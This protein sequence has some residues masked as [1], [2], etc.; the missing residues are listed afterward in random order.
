MLES[1]VSPCLG[2]HIQEGDTDRNDYSQSSGDPWN[3][4]EDEKV[5]EEAE[6]EEEGEEGGDGEEA[7]EEEQEEEMD[8]GEGDEEKE[9]EEEEA[10][11]E[12]HEEAEVSALALPAL[13][14]I[15]TQKKDRKKVNPG[16]GKGKGEDENVVATAEEKNHANTA[17]V[18]Q[19]KRNGKG[20]RGKSGGKRDAGQL[21]HTAKAAGVPPKPIAK[22]G[23]KGK[24]KDS[25][26]KGKGKDSAPAALVPKS[27]KNKKGNDDA[28]PD[29][30]ATTP[31][32]P[33]NNK[34]KATSQETPDKPSLPPRPASKVALC[35]TSPLFFVFMM[36]LCDVHLRG[37]LLRLVMNHS[38]ASYMM[39]LY[40]FADRSRC[41]MSLMMCLTT[42]SQKSQKSPKFQAAGGQ[43]SGSADRTTGG[44]HPKR[45]KVARTEE[46]AGIWAKTEADLMKKLDEAPQCW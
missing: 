41:M 7:E 26:P 34:R 10:E 5:E 40:M 25:A 16:K 15:K 17:A 46:I 4:L 22:P 20:G 27:G 13:E 33:P 43:P 1:S 12:E 21:G 39:C 31:S 18:A 24:G 3:L 37:I 42:K 9:E 38:H 36:R 11:E 30:N 14:D 29:A 6:E 23:K 44:K 2:S 19:L 35:F 28:D 8:E 32:K 45:G